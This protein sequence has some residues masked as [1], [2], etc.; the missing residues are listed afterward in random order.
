MSCRHRWARLDGVSHGA[1]G[2]CAAQRAGESCAATES[3]VLQ[4]CGRCGAL[5]VRCRGDFRLRR[6]LRGA[7]A[8]RLFDLCG[9]TAVEAYVS[10]VGGMFLAAA[11]GEGRTGIASLDAEDVDERWQRAEEFCTHDCLPSDMVCMAL[12]VV[13]TSE[14]EA[15]EGDVAEGW[16]GDVSPLTL[17]TIA[18]RNALIRRVAEYRG[19]A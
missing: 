18:A 9:Q 1:D 4:R 2:R 17:V 3:H 6:R 15:E 5:R 11:D 19:P 7:S 8:E 16:G 14:V 10:R 13:A 12:C